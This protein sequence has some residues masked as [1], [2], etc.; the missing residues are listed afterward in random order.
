MHLEKPHAKVSANLSDFKEWGQ[1]ESFCRC[2]DW[3]SMV[4][5]CSETLLAVLTDLIL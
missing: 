2:D 4:I 5:R 3:V 1:W